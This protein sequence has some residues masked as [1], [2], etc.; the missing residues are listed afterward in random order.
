MKAQKIKLLTSC[1]HRKSSPSFQNRCI[2]WLAV[3][4]A[5]M[6]LYSI[7]PDDT[8]AVPLGSQLDP[9]SVP[10][11]PELQNTFGIVHLGKCGGVSMKATLKG[12]SGSL[13]R[14]GQV[15]ARAKWYHL[16]KPEV[17]AY[18]NW[19]L[20]VRDPIARIQSWWMYDHTDN[21]LHR[22]DNLGHPYRS[23]LWPRVFECYPTLDEFLTNGLAPTTTPPDE[24]QSLAQMAAPLR[25]SGYVTGLQH[26][27][28][29]F[30]RYFAPL[31]AAEDK[32]LYVVRAEHMLDDLNSVS[33]ELGEDR[34]TLTGV[35]H[36]SHWRNEAYLNKDRSI[37]AKGMENLCRHLCNEIQL[38][39]QIL[40]RGINMRKETRTKSL[41]QLSQ[42]CPLQANA[43]DC[44]LGMS[45]SEWSNMDKHFA[46]IQRVEIQQVVWDA[47]DWHKKQSKS[48]TALG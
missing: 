27:R 10:P 28:F 39:K 45:E 20:L 19:I 32:K 42:S 6:L 44:P 4:L 36:R 8:G 29:N 47:E 43:A 25:G 22:Q 23:K 2:I 46:A 35:R 15:A 34:S 21:F 9:P 7:R 14:I 26:M 5:V 16:A 17:D 41:D 38:Y 12:Y 11:A 37:S 24:C 31:L 33:S 18:Q 3:A 30:E 48:P 13:T 1:W 40:E